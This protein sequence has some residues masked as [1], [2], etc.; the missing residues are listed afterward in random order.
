[1][2][3]PDANAHDQELR[4]SPPQEPWHDKVLVDAIGYTKG[5]VAILDSL[6][7]GFQRRGREL[8]DQRTRLTILQNERRTILEERS[9][10]DA[11]IAALSAE[12][13]GL[14]IALEE[15]E[16][17]L[18]E[19]RTRLA[20]LDGERHTMLDER[21]AFDA[22][23]AALSAERDGLRIALE[24]S[25]QALD[26]LRREALESQGVL[27][28]QTRD[29]QALRSALA[30]PTRQ[31]EELREV[32][33]SLE[34]QLQRAGQLPARPSTTPPPGESATSG[35]DRA[36]PQLDAA[37]FEELFPVRPRAED[38]RITALAALIAERDGL[39]TALEERERELDRLRRD[40]AEGQAKLEAQTREVQA[41]RIGMAETV[42]QAEEIRK[43][44][45]ALEEESE[46]EA[47]R[48]AILEEALEVERRQVR[49]AVAR[50]GQ[51]QAA[52]HED[53]ADAENLLAEARK[54]IATSQGLIANLQRTV[55]AE[56]ARSAA[57]QDKLEAQTAELAQLNVTM[58]AVPL[59]LNELVKAFGGSGEA[60]RKESDTEGREP[61]WLEALVQDPAVVESSD[62]E[63][64][65]ILQPIRE[66]LRDLL[67]PAA[68][69]TARPT[70]LA[71]DPIALRRR[72]E[73]IADQWRRVV[74]KQ[75][76]S[77]R[78]AE[79]VRE[80]RGP[81]LPEQSSTKAADRDPRPEGEAAEAAPGGRPTAGETPP[82]ARGEPSPAP[83]GAPG[84]REKVTR[85]PGSPSGMTVECRLP[86]SGTEPA[87]IL[88]GEIGRINDMGMLG[89]FE[90]RF[91][92]G[93]QVTVRFVREG[94]LVSCVGRVVR[95][96][97]SAAA[98]DAPVVFNHL[99]RFE[100][101]V[102]PA[103]DNPTR[104]G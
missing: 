82:I 91:S 20:T 90:E 65:A 44:L 61:A 80:A 77:T 23:I 74:R 94:E 1:M 100:S 76:E 24:E 62:R 45:Q 11:R 97:E 85:R 22:R 92:E 84:A 51:E 70:A 57:L 37:A 42:R 72:A 36:T 38:G 75:A 54:D 31:A 68:G 78:P 34:R 95:V 33:R 2:L 55:D 66:V 63:A 39:R 79:S 25:E 103:G 98:P 83:T 58:Q 59:L 46:N 41:L 13:D 4:A 93:Q 43:V 29:I 30:E 71:T 47:R 14:R 15:S 9:A 73:E 99:I 32:V 8:E 7:E 60:S 48:H 40:V 17:A 10:F 88:R 49:E 89:A 56:R 52:L 26:T 18:E 87:R 53:L 81:R 16:Q 28:K 19:Q 27:E 50:A 64:L 5:L 101:P 102:A 67:P 86:A 3:E 6:S 35:V 104:V 12:R 21:S 96:Q 69:I